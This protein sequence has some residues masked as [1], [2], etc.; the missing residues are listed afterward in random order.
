M[1]R[2]RHRIFHA[3]PSGP[4][5][6]CVVAAALYH[7]PCIMRLRLNRQ[8]M[9]MH[10]ASA[11]G[12]ES[13]FIVTVIAHVPMCGWA[14][15]CVRVCS[16]CVFEHGCACARVRV[17]GTARVRMRVCVLR[18]LLVAAGCGSA[19]PLLQSRTTLSSHCHWNR[20]HKGFAWFLVC[21]CG[22]RVCRPAGPPQKKVVGNRCL[23][24][25][26]VDGSARI[27]H[28]RVR[29]HVCACPTCGSQSWCLP[30]KMMVVGSET[31]Y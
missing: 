7:A 6:G 10:H 28:A 16:A 25:D 27:V 19:M 2:A 1:A 14:V 29:V 13:L 11:R 3:P 20:M 30:R 31:L 21:V 22:W 12:R 5:K 23:Q 18:V 24:S 4:L 9:H 26:V 17:R 8:R 15:S